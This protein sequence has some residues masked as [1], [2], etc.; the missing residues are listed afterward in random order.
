MNAKS[1]EEAIQTA[2]LAW[3]KKYDIQD[4]DPMRGIAEIF[5]IYLG[6][7]D[8]AAQTVEPTW[9][10]EFCEALDIQNQRIKGFTKAAT[11]LSSRIQGLHSA[12]T[13]GCRSDRLAGLFNGSLVF[14]AGIAV[15]RFL[16]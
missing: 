12:N 4:T 5:E 14:A 6:P 9:F 16:L 3:A 13:G 2:V 7:Y 15:G 8:P 11:E 10:E 1:R